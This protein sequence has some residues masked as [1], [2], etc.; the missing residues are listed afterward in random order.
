[1]SAV[2][3]GG[4]GMLWRRCDT[5]SAPIAGSETMTNCADGSVPATN[6]LQVDIVGYSC[7][8][9]AHV[10]R[11]ITINPSPPTDNRPPDSGRPG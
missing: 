1:M 9:Y 3:E 6:Q 2:M 8:R 11:K 10:R 7:K 5:V 4:L